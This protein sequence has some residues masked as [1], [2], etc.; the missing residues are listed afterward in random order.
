MTCDHDLREHTNAVVGM[1][2]DD[3]NYYSQMVEDAS[4]LHGML[5]GEQD[6][7][8]LKVFSPYYNKKNI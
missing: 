3:R 4:R 2:R 6:R 5:T 8:K 1:K 7:D